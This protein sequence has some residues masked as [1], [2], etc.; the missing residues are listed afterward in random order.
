MD[1]ANPANNL[2]ETGIIAGGCTSYSYELEHGEWAE[3]VRR[4]D[5]I[6]LTKTIAQIQTDN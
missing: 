5:N 4:I 3:L 6:D 1:P 2:H